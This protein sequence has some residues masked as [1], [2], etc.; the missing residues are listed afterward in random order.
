MEGL[1][2]SIFLK[3]IVAS[4]PNVFFKPF[5]EYQEHFWLLFAEYQEVKSEML[6][7]TLIIILNYFWVG[8][9]RAI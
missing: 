1:K 8:N 2:I 6:E 9:P 5:Q 7:S 4:K 3:D